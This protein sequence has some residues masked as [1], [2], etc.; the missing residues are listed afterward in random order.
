MRDSIPPDILFFRN[1]FSEPP[2]SSLTYCE[3]LAFSPIPFIL[4]NH[5]LWS[6]RYH[7]Q[8][9]DIAKCPCRGCLSC[10]NAV[11]ALKQPNIKNCVFNF[12]YIR[13]SR[14]GWFTIPCR[15]LRGAILFSLTHRHLSNL[16]LHTLNSA[17]W[18]YTPFSAQKPEQVFIKGK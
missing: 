16:M 4:D 17:M 7:V 2:R 3:T 13:V 15:Q 5:S 18:Y 6:K 8:N 11:P 9:S 14:Q 10:T 12:C 1:I